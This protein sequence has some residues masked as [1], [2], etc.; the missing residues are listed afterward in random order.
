MPHYYAT[1]GTAIQLD[2]APD[3]IGVRFEGATGP[4]VARS[5]VR[6][7]TPAPKAR[8]AAAETERRPPTAA[9]QHFGRFMLLRESGAAERP[10]ETVVN[11]LPHRLATHVSRTMPVFI[12]R[13]SQLKLVATD[14]ILVSFKTNASAARTRKLLDGLGLTVIGTSEFDRSRKILVPS[15]VRRA[16]RTLD[17]ANQLVEADDLVSY[18]AP[19]FLAEVRKRTLNDPQFGRQWHLDNTGQPNGIAGEDVR[20]LAAWAKVDGGT[21]AV[22]IAIID[23]GIDLNHPDLKTNIWTN[24]SRTARDRHGRDFLDDLDPYNPNPK[25]FNAPFDDTDT[26][27]IHGTPCA[28]VAAA[29][30]N[31][32]KG[33]VGMAW[34]CRL[35]AVKILAGPSLAPNDRIADAI[36]YAA[37]HAD[38]LS[39]SWGVA[40][41]P[42]IESA[43]D[44][45]VERGRRGRGSIVCV[46]T[47]NDGQSRI[48]F[49]STHDAA[50]AVGACNDRGRRSSYSNYG[51]GIDIVAPSNDD[52]PRRQGITTTDV[53]FRGKGYSSGAYC[54]DFGGTSS[55]TPLVAGCA[56]LVLSANASLSWD[57]ARDVLTSTAEKID[58]TNGRYTRGYSL[59]YGYGRVNAA[60]AVDAALARPRRRGAR[61]TA[62]KAARKKR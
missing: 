54:D 4:T 61:K 8:R 57:G 20:A 15:S 16:S 24:P 53:S 48:G 55:A 39:C 45:A 30:G 3:A 60:A 47:G 32:G 11:A 14:Q 35:M 12:E 29:V 62:H 58:R 25:V 37:Q 41:H 13:E 27:D 22:V 50:V 6:A 52:D 17:L 23:D 40:R 31:N 59:Q 18:A 1:S 56:A 9:V 43:I 21:P 28:G 38:V 10:V 7:L 46:A 51:T 5:A 19:N 44:Y 33:V 26:N 2:E 36:R 34:N 49:P 42:D